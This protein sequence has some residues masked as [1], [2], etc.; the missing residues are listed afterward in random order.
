[1]DELERLVDVYRLRASA[2]VAS[3]LDVLMDLE[4]IRDPRVVPFLLGVLRNSG[5]SEEVRIYVLKQ[6]RSGDGLLVPPDR[7]GVARAIGDVLSDRSTSDLRLQA[8]LALGQFTNVAGVLSTLKTVA[9]SPAES[10]DLRYAAFTSLERA[11]PTPECIELLRELSRDETLGR[12]AQS[13]LST[14]RVA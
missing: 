8:A 6:L 13:V 1:M 2:S 5:E 4:R 10:I 9:S 12:S 7:P 14:W 11:G 3:K